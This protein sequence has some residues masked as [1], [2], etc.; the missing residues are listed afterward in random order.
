MRICVSSDLQ[1]CYPGVNKW[2]GIRNYLEAA[3]LEPGNVL[4]IGD[5]M[6][7]Y[8]MLLNAGVSVAVENAKEAVK[9]VADRVFASNDE[10]GVA[11]ALQYYLLRGGE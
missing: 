3:D 5:G 10:D 9:D 11:K 1:W 4:A 2:E 8:E 6:N 7:D